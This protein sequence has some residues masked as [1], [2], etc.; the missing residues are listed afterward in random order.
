[1]RSSAAVHPRRSAGSIRSGPAWRS[2]SAAR[3][4]ARPWPA[5]SSGARPPPARPRWTRGWRPRPATREPRRYRPG[6]HAAPSFGF[7]EPAPDLLVVVLG[8]R[9]RLLDL[10]VVLQGRREVVE[11]VLPARRGLS[12]EGLAG[13]GAIELVGGK[14]EE[15]QRVVRGP[16]VLIL[17]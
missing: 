14:G 7:L 11:V 12:Q 10:V 9:P 3:A 13:G 2:R 15:I 8:A 17:G 4:D 1:A 16:I 6:A 5:P